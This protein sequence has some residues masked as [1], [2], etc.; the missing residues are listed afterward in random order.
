VWRTFAHAS[1][2]ASG[3]GLAFQHV[4]LLD[5]CRSRIAA[6]RGGVLRTA[7]LLA[8]RDD[9]IRGSVL[10]L[11]VH[12]MSASAGRVWNS[13]RGYEPAPID[14]WHSADMPMGSLFER[15]EDQAHLLH[16]QSAC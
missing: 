4:I 2:G 1:L 15:R 7:P 5:P 11:G 10:P 13:I 12:D 8:Y 16:Q 14:A 3:F 6:R 9:V